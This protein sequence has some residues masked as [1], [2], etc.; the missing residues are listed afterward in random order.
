MRPRSRQAALSPL[1][2]IAMLQKLESLV[3]ELYHEADRVVAAYRHRTALCCPVGCLQ[4]CF[5]EKI[6][7]TVLEM[8][9]VA[10][11][12]FRTNQAELVIK[13]LE[14]TAPSRQCILLRAD[15]LATGGQGCSQ[16]PHRALV[17]RL[18]GF[19]GN[20]DRHGVPR[21]AR[22]RHM[23]PE[24]EAGSRNPDSVDNEN[25]MPLFQRFGVTLTAIH[26]GL[27]TVRRPINEALLEALS[28]VGLLLEL[29]RAAPEDDGPVEQ[30]PE[31]PPTPHQPTLRKK[32]A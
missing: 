18:F 14:K 17:C 15:L 11:Q 16:Y 30:P 8:V 6:E 29:Q 20:L 5:S 7:A 31:S 24:Q 19:A 27:G 1:S 28:K 22:C 25:V 21:L 26:P 2:S 23:G 3:L 4:C 10:F 12:L 9:P 13:R 32:A